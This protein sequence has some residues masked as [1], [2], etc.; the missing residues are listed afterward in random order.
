[1]NLFLSLLIILSCRFDSGFG[2][3]A[4][5]DPNVTF[6][7]IIKSIQID[8]GFS[9]YQNRS[10]ESIAE[11]LKLNGFRVVHYFVTNE[12][13]VDGELVQA[14]KDCGVE[15]WLMTL[16]NGTY[17]TA[18]YP[19]GWESWKMEFTNGQ[20]GTGGYTFLSPFNEEFVSWKKRKLVGLMTTY[21]FDGIELAEAYLP[22][23][24]GMSRGH[25][26]DVGPNA[27]EA[28]YAIYGVEMPDFTDA[29]D[30]RYY[31]N[32]PKVYEKWMTFRV[33]GVN[34][35]LNEIFNGPNGIRESR[36]DAKIATWS[37]AIDAGDHPVKKLREDQGLDVPAMIELVQPDLHYIQTHWPD[38]IKSEEQLPADYIKAYEP[39]IKEI[40]NIQPDLPVGIQAD[41]GSNANMV[42]S[43]EWIQDF[44]HFSEK[45]GYDVMTAYEY[46]LGGYIYD[47][48]PR[49]MKTDRIGSDRIGLSFQKRIHVETT[50]KSDNFYFLDNN[51]KRIYPTINKINIDGNRV[52]LKSRDFPEV[53]FY[54][55]I[56]KLRDT[57]EFWLYGKTSANNVE[58]IKCYIE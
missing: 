23:W 15:V 22:S 32:I 40:K 11:E 55:I 13:K 17:S 4:S 5:E 33:N 9:Y 29:D 34:H 12:N 46:H 3:S 26:G 47:E 54:V 41:I 50:I 42:K 52:E 35:F 21:P 14:L 6:D 51:K 30:P 8:P 48:A 36:S 49:L 18:N 43:Q 24:N 56:Q 7:T 19:K 39:F 44:I 20:N 45:E 10:P 38:W 16:G 31:K 27:Q 1:M 37:L 25:Y 57:P 58:N 28:F 2:K 53:P